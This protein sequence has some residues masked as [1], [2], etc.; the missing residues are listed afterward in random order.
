MIFAIRELTL[1]SI[2]VD[3]N[4]EG[5]FFDEF[6]KFS[7]NRPAQ[8]VANLMDRH[9]DDRHY[10]VLS[11]DPN[12]PSITRL[13]I[14]EIKEGDSTRLPFMSQ[15]PRAGAIGP[16]I[17]RNKASQKISPSNG[18]INKTIKNLKENSDSKQ[19]WSTYFE[20]AHHCLTAKKVE[21]EGS[22]RPA[23]NGALHF[24]VQSVSIP[25]AMIAFEDELSRLP[26]DVDE[27]IQFFRNSIVS[28]KYVTEDTPP[29]M[30]KCGC[31]NSFV[32]VHPNA[33][34]GSGFNFSNKDHPWSFPSNNIE[35]A[36]KRFALCEDCA[37]LLRIFAKRMLPDY[38]TRIAGEKCLV[39]PL[40]SPDSERKAK[41]ISRFKKWVLA[42]NAGEE[43]TLKAREDSLLKLLAHDKAVN[44]LNILWASFG[45]QVDDVK[46]TLSEVLPSRLQELDAQNRKFQKVE[47]PAFPEHKLDDFRIDLSL[48]FLLELFKRPG[49]DK[50]KN[51]NKSKR[52][53]DLRREMVSAVYH[54]R[55]IEA[56]R[57][58]AR[59]D[60]ELMKTATWHLMDIF[61]SG[62][63]NRLIYEG[64]NQKNNTTY[65]TFAGWVRHLA[66][67]LYY[68]R[69]IG[70]L[71]MPA[72]ETIYQPELDSLKPY[73]S[74]ETAIDSEPKAFA[75]LLGVLYGKVMQVQAARG[76]NVGANALTWLKRL[77]L[78]GKDLQQLYIK[79]REKLLSYETES[80]KPVREVVEELGR[81]GSR[82][83]NLNELDETNTCYFLLLGQSL[84]TTILPSQSKSEGDE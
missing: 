24:A 39:L 72:T 61:A 54:G 81:L 3:Q 42:V 13:E 8:M 64:L 57:T 16:I 26:G 47:H 33:L 1:A 21:F 79:V 44:E 17:K 59:F 37:N 35:D 9:T 2:A 22:I 83:Q 75:F 18:T 4:F 40:L 84:A 14:R 82:V 25:S 48:A 19:I 76:V 68:L 11:T 28:K 15:P 51:A 78:T 63:W 71:P 73:F 30:G 60:D 10:F 29:T 43:G 45:D 12:D 23:P 80:S 36:W 49:G 7:S 38:T 20:K 5:S 66:K 32:E 62:K 74:E 69:T 53:F 46:G 56:S 65:L 55:N 6:K 34:S 31:C 27:Y 70:V 77:T 52:L 58:K 50:S 41:F 67:I